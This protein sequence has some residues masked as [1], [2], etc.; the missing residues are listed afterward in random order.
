MSESLRSLSDQQLLSRVDD[1]VAKDRKLT[2]D[3][4]IHLR[5][6]ERR[7]LYLE[8]G[9]SSMFVYCTAR[10]KY[11]EPSAVR[12]IAAAR[13]LAEFPRLLPLLESGEVNPTTVSMI[14]KHIKPENA[15]AVLDAITG[16]S[17]REV[18]RFV[19]A[20]QPLSVIPADRVRPIVVPVHDWGKSTFSA[21]GK[22]SS[23]ALETATAERDSHEQPA[24]VAPASA[25]PLQFQRCAR[26]EFTAHED[27]MGKFDRIRS[28]FSHRLSPGSSLEQLLALMA[29]YVLRREDPVEREKRRSDAPRASSQSRQNDLENPRAIPARIRDQVFQRDG[30]R[31]TYTA[32]GGRLCN[33]THMLQ[34]DHK[35]PVA[36]GGKSTVE[37][38]RLLCA[39][40]N[41]LE[42]ERLMGPCG[43][44]R[45]AWRGRAARRSGGAPDLVQ[46]PIT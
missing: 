31:C 27:L 9:Y 7:R 16:K 23:T 35:I 28:L 29:D 4:L 10:L 17:T 22:K 13:C 18:E 33:S 2:L 5:E 45:S 20:L 25:A 26:V 32:E 14:A 15:D 30:G 11:S 38:L 41:R 19:A 40:H 8:L 34:L 43:P 37:N 24:P 1:I 6:V 12:R 44:T 36:R 42:A 46:P 39:Y 21:D 3:L